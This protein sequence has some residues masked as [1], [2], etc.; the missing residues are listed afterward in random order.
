MK[1]SFKFL[2][3][4]LGF[5]L[6][7]LFFSAHVYG[8]ETVLFDGVIA[9]EVVKLR[10]GPGT[11]HSVS[12]ELKF[13]MRVAVLEQNARRDGDDPEASCAGYYWYRVRTASGVSGWAYGKGVYLIEDQD[14]ESFEGPDLR[15]YRDRTWRVHDREMKFGCAVEPN[16]YQ[17]SGMEDC[18]M[19]YLPFFYLEGKDKVFPL[20]DGDWMKPYLPNMIG[21]DDIEGIW[22]TKEHDADVVIRFGG[23]GEDSYGWVFYY[24]KWKG[25]YFELVKDLSLSGFSIGY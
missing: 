19:Q 21:G 24:L 16:L 9:R 1:G 6:A 2:K 12:G 18:E 23:S 20:K 4:C 14:A 17:E 22:K 10:R 8:Q 3:Q 25:Q 5:V 15:P 11:E 13:G 7:L